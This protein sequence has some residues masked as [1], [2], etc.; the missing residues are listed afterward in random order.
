MI[1]VAVLAAI[2][3]LDFLSVR[4]QIP[5]RPTYGAV[6]VKDYYAVRMKNGKTEI[7]PGDADTV[8]CVNSVFPQLGL[9]PC[10]YAGRHTRQIVKMN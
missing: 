5:G 4:F 10:W 9:E 2:Y 8:Q 6:P 7:M 3:A 1:A